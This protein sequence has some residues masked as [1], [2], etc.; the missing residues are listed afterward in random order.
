MTS[1]KDGHHLD[2]CSFNLVNADGDRLGAVSAVDCDH[3]YLP[4]LENLVNIIAHIKAHGYDAVNGG[5]SDG[6]VY[7]GPYRG[8]D[9]EH[10]VMGLAN[11]R[12]P[13]DYAMRIWV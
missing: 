4:L 3:R 5:V 10:V 12:Y 8:Y 13:L 11:L 2:S 9:G 6:F 1:I 7:G